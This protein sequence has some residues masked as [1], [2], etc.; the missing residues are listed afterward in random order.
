MAIPV[1]SKNLAD[2]FKI[3]HLNR[4]E[5]LEKIL[6]IYCYARVTEPGVMSLSIEHTCQCY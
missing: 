4:P 1:F 6:Y 3:L 2:T 5:S